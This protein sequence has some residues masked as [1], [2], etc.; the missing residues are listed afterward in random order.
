[1]TRIETAA[2]G[3][4]L[5]ELIGKRPLLLDGAMGSVLI[6]KGIASKQPPECLNITHPDVI[7]SIHR[8]YLEAGSHCVTTNTFGASHFHLKDAPYSVTEIIE[9]AVRNAR[10][11][12]SL[13]KAEDE[14]QGKV[15]PRFVLLD[16]GPLGQLMEPM[17]S[18]TFEAAYEAFKEQI[19]AAGNEIDGIIIETISDLYEMKAAVLAAK[20]NSTCPILA[21]MTFEAGGRTL[22]GT[23]PEIM[24]TVLEGL[25]VSALGANCSLGPKELAPIVERILQTSGIPVLIQPNAGLPI[26]DGE[27]THYDIDP[28]SFTAAVNQFFEQGISLAGGCCGTSPAYIKAL[29]EVWGE[30][31]LNPPTVMPQTRI[32]SSRELVTFD[33]SIVVCGERLNPTGKPKLKA[34]LLAEDMDMLVDE[35]LDQVEAGA[36]VLDLNVG[37][38][39]IDEKAVM[40][41]A[42]KA[43]SEMC[44][45][46]LQLDS[47]N[48]AVLEAACRIYDGKPLLNS[49]NGKAEVMAAV[50][51]IVKK[52]GAAVIGLTLDEKGIPARA[53]ERLAIAKTIVDKAAEYG[54][55][56][57]NI[58][59]DCLVLTAAAQQAEV[60][61]T[62]KAI[63]LVKEQ[64]GVKTVLGC[65]NVSFGLPNRPLLNKTFLAMAFYAGLDLAIIN[66]LD[67]EL[68][69]TISAYEVLAAV[70]QNSERYVQKFAATPP[71]SN[72]NSSEKVTLAIPK[73]AKVEG[74]GETLSQLIIL[75]KKVEAEKAALSL[76]KDH[77]PLELVTEHIIPA[78]R[79]VGRRYETGQ[80]FLPQ[81]IMS[82]ETAKIAFALLKTQLEAQGQGQQENKGLIVLA[83]VQ[84]DVH[85]IGKN[86]VR[87]V[88]ESYGYEVLDLGR[89]VSPEVIADT[90]IEK[91]P[92]L[93]GLSALMTT[94]VPSM[95]KTI[96]KL[97][98][99]P[100]CCPVIVGGAV[101]TAE[102][103]ARIGADFYA[104]D[105]LAAVTVAEGISNNK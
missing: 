48:P 59:I 9:A 105:A 3:N 17:G 74:V 64:L 92:I 71:V 42:V 22:T 89:D 70:D 4:T 100:D 51:P 77:P 5:A 65:S 76:L 26:F 2:K 19:L 31:K 10:A 91:H 29:A 98:A 81:L 103:A 36:K 28:Q 54:I 80:Y 90:M 47:S 16:L 87:I 83:T 93:I 66:P 58:I 61:E 11:A 68:M 60:L 56:P 88:L 23:S 34:A 57:E 7:T 41:S 50:F 12:V 39:G 18:L 30:G 25:G 24:V 97:K 84:G 95:E 99:L 33:G 15:K 53:E 69:D 67:Q 44:R 43:V 37:L 46:P 49:V 62:L 75:G 79:E 40:I 104:E 45:V 13:Q 73:V 52:Y 102:L 86:I 6:Q 14:K 78:L 27:K 72:S 20:E 63:T 35:A 101:V 94:T 85:D 32:C 38:P 82:A 1:M 8:E 55:A 96:K 21:T